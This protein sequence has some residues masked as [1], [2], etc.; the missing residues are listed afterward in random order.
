MQLMKKFFITFIIFLFA[1]LFY[2][3]GQQDC[4][5]ALPVC[6]NANSGGV[7]NG[8]GRDD[9]NGSLQSGCLKNGLN[10]ATIETNSFWFKVKL[11]ES[12]EFGFDIK[13]NN[14]SEDWDFAVYGPSPSC[15]GLGDPIAC[16]YSKVSLTGYTGV[17]IDPVNGT[18]TDAYDSWMNATT[19]DEYVILVNQY[20]GTNS[21]FSINWKGAVI[22]TS[23]NPLDCDILVDLGPDRDLCVGQSTPLN[24]IFLELQ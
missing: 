21:G 22:T 13:P 18:Q 23:A 14:L 11:A 1:G 12:G 4:S 19:G 8:F 17:G 16:N 2:G 9:F 10:A 7:V 6:T 20:S 15:G 3:Y 5:N 24:A